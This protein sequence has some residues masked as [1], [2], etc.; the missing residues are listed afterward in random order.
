MYPEAQAIEERAGA[1]NALVLGAHA[2][3]ICQWI[4]RVRDNQDHGPR[5]GVHYARHQVAVDVGVPV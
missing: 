2:R 4:R 1:E 5:R 3:D